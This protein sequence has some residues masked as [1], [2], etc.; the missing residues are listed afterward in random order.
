MHLFRKHSSR[1]HSSRI[2]IVARP[3]LAVLVASGLTVLLGA[4]VAEAVQESGAN[5][6]LR[7]ARLVTVPLPINESAAAVVKQQIGRFADEAPI[8]VQ[9]H[10]RP[11]LVLEFDTSGQATGQGSELGVCLDL[12]TLLTDTRLQGVHTVAYV[13][14]ARGAV[15]DDSGLPASRLQGHA[16][17]VAMACNEIAMHEQSALGRAGADVR[18]DGT[19]ETTVYSNVA[20]RRLTLPLP[21]ALAMVDSSRSLYRVETATGVQFTDQ[22]GLDR[23]EGEGKVIDST[24]LSRAGELPMFSSETLFEAQLIRYRVGSR[25]DLASRLSIDGAAIEGNPAADGQ[26]RSAELR[27]GGLIDAREADWD[28]RM[29]NSH[30]AANPDTNLIIARFNCPGGEIDACLRIARALADLDPARVRTVAFIETEASGPASLVA[31]ACD[32]I[33]MA[34]KATIGGL[35]EGGISREALDDA[36]PLIQMLAEAKQRDASVLTG[37]VDPDVSLMRFR[38]KSTGQVRL[39]SAEERQSLPRPDDWLELDEVELAVALSAAE[40]MNLMLARATVSDFDQLKKFYQL[41]ESP[42]PLE[43]SP[44][45]R[46]I[47]SLAR[48]MASPWIA[49]WLLFGAVFLLSTEMSHP[50]IGIPG[51]LGTICLMLFF[52]SQYLDGNANWLEILLFVAGM[53]FLVL[54]VFVLPGFGIF[55]IGGL[56]MIVVSIVLA[57]QTFVIPRNSEELARMPVSLSLVLAAAGGFFAAVFVLRRYL[58]T[59]PVFRRIMLEPPGSDATIS[60]SQREQQESVTRR[61][62]LMGRTGMSTSPLVPAGKAQIGNELIDVITDGRMVERGTAI[63]V[64]QVLGNRVIVEPENGGPA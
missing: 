4:Q 38:N 14:Q 51:F 10:K 57:S 53:L 64:V 61:E 19:L 21:V 30:L 54:E 25:G 5:D 13:P 16:V 56:A 58:T 55:G 39:L 29:L 22:E 17:L 15:P 12:A 1:K 36:R 59:L 18:G 31:M 47:E 11:V 44:T 49:F 20:G 7:P 3:G 8:A 32:Q 48:H 26:W 62:H 6:L 9:P 45:D 43:P 46:W 24:T 33:I 2:R 60:P 27:L 35:T 34:D 50:G 42:V 40:A 28:I 37:L 63:R 41:H 23:L 52:W